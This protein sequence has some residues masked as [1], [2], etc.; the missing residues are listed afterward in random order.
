[1]QITLHRAVSN[2]TFPLS[3]VADHQSR[4]KEVKPLLNLTKCPLLP[5]IAVVYY[6]YYEKLCGQTSSPTFFN[7]W[8]EWRPKSA[9]HIANRSSLVAWCGYEGILI[10]AKLPEDGDASAQGAIDE[11]YVSVLYLSRQGRLQSGSWRKL[12]DQS[13]TV[14]KAAEILIHCSSSLNI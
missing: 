8:K 3:L 10:Y 2:H 1:M 14:L 11:P 13:P 4:R 5:V 6:S 12:F 9:D 7:S